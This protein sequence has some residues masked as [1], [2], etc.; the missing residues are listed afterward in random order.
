MNPIWNSMRLLMLGIVY[1]WLSNLGVS[2]SHVLLLKTSL[3]E[4]EPS[5]KNL[6]KAAFRNEL[7]LLV[8][9]GMMLAQFM[10]ILSIY[11]P[12]L[13]AFWLKPHVWSLLSTPY[14]FFY[15]CKMLMASM[16]MSIDDSRYRY[17]D[18][19]IKRHLFIDSFIGQ[20]HN[21]IVLPTPLFVRVLSSSLFRYSQASMFMSGVLVGWLGGS[22][23]LILMTCML[24]YTL[25]R[26]TPSFG[27]K[28]DVFYF[29]FFRYFA[30]VFAL[31][32]INI[33]PILITRDNLPLL[34]ANTMR[35]KD[36][37]PNI[38]FDSTSYHRQLWFPT[39][40]DG[41]EEQ[42]LIIETVKEESKPFIPKE[43]LLNY[44]RVSQYF[45]RESVHAG[46]ARLL[47]NYPASL[48]IAHENLEIVLDYPFL[49]QDNLDRIYDE[50]LEDKIERRDE[51]SL[52]VF[53]RLSRINRLRKT[54]EK[55]VQKKLILNLETLKTN[56]KT[57]E[58]QHANINID[59]ILS[60]NLIGKNSPNPNVSVVPPERRKL[61]NFE[62][63][64]NNQL[65]EWISDKAQDLQEIVLL[66]WE[67]L[68]STS[69]LALPLVLNN[70]LNNYDPVFLH[71]N[72][73]SWDR[74]VQAYKAPLIP[75]YPE[76][77]T[78]WFINGAAWVYNVDL[79]S[80]FANWIKT[81]LQK[82]FGLIENLSQEEKRI[83]SFAA[84]QQ[85]LPLYTMS[86]YNEEGDPIESMVNRQE[87]P[88][89]GEQLLAIS[90]NFNDEI[91]L[92]HNIPR[93]RKGQLLKLRQLQFLPPSVIHCKALQEE[94]GVNNLGLLF[95]SEFNTITKF[96]YQLVFHQLKVDSN[97]NWDAITQALM[98]AYYRNL[99]IRNRQPSITEG[100][101]VLDSHFNNI[102]GPWLI[103]QFYLRKYVRLPLMIFVKHA[104]RMFFQQ[105]SELER[106]L[107]E[108]LQEESRICIYKGDEA[109]AP[110][111]ETAEE[112]EEEDKKS[113]DKLTSAEKA[114]DINSSESAKT[115]TINEGEDGLATSNMDPLE[116]EIKSIREDLDKKSKKHKPWIFP[117]NWLD[118]GIQIKILY[119]FEFKFSHD[120]LDYE[121]TFYAKL[122]EFV[123]NYPHLASIVN[124]Q[125]L[126]G[127][128]DL[129][130]PESCYLDMMGFEVETPAGNQRTFRSTFSLNIKLIARRFVLVSRIRIAKILTP[131]LR[132]PLWQILARYYISVYANIK[133]ILSFVK[134][135]LIIIVETIQKILQV[136]ETVM[137]KMRT[138]QKT[139]V[140]SPNIMVSSR[141][142]Q[143]ASIPST[144]KKANRIRQ[145]KSV[146]FPKFDQFIQS[147]LENTLLTRYPLFE[148]L[149]DALFEG[150]SFKERLLF[151]LHY[152][153]SQIKFLGIQI[154]KSSVFAKQ[155]LKVLLTIEYPTWIKLQ[156]QLLPNSLRLLRPIITQ[157]LI[158]SRDNCLDALDLYIEKIASKILFWLHG[159]NKL[160]KY[161][162]EIKNVD[163]PQKLSLGLTHSF[164]W[165][166]LWE[167]QLAIN[168]HLIKIVEDWED[169][170]VLSPKIHRFLVDEGI[171]EDEVN[172][173]IVHDLLL[174]K[175]HLSKWLRNM[176][177]F[178]PPKLVWSSLK[179]ASKKKRKRII[180][181]IQSHQRNSFSNYQTPQHSLPELYDLLIKSA[182]N[183]SKLTQWYHLLQAYISEYDGIRIQNPRLRGRPVIDRG[184]YVKPYH[185]QFSDFGENT[186]LEY[187][188][189]DEAS[190]QY[191]CFESS[192]DIFNRKPIEEEDAMLDALLFPLKTT[193]SS[194]VPLEN[195]IHDIFKRINRGF[196]KIVND[197]TKFEQYEMKP[198]DIR[199]CNGMSSFLFGQ[200]DISNL[201]EADFETFYDLR[202]R[203]PI[204][205]WRMKLMN[206]SLFTFNFVTP[207]FEFI[208]L[209]KPCDLKNRVEWLLDSADKLMFCRIYESIM[210][211]D[212]QRE[213]RV[214]NL[215]NLDQ[216]LPHSGDKMLGSYSAISK[217]SEEV[218]SRFLWPSHRLE[219][220][221]CMNRFWFG[222]A[223]Q[224][225]S[226]LFRIRMYPLVK[227]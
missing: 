19:H 202:G 72:N 165:E 31:I 26:F 129:Q 183:W 136:I 179:I 113:T 14:I 210:L 181:K 172:S 131:I 29:D 33:S 104:I 155:Y 224:S 65:K 222:V 2:K 52:K 107:E 17:E 128:T 216:P 67:P 12:P 117:E 78:F 147:K 53:K 206:E 79:M 45:F 204:L 27:K 103:C 102:R 213:F 37:W 16:P 28:F 13:Y 198:L 9:S 8:L 66:P 109:Q 215:L 96:K 115:N 40:K 221:A 39:S 24:V 158:N 141:S 191:F 42:D 61:N 225:K 56:Q 193:R 170:Q 138:V 187:L 163:K 10:V 180:T 174:T 75:D 205:N 122:R 20:L 106:D 203:A 150:F 97:R 201:D 173:N 140:P 114:K 192:M 162:I 134:K 98:S 89:I 182:D 152:K 186:N 214:L 133:A 38:L 111:E 85:N 91:A 197:D 195:S 130:K 153:F 227:P 6:V 58:I 218:F 3:Y 84:L 43:M 51:I 74:F 90:P 194:Y 108:L 22:I 132:F 41:F 30:V 5:K 196:F 145:R 32:S 125:E 88:D 86:N 49:S 126:I 54:F 11:L 121:K 190:D 95:L 82:Q 50:W 87:E 212:L 157:F 184:S 23:L 15:A 139:I 68:S 73:F 175:Q 200:P 127:E 46:K 142:T 124:V 208:N 112:E 156:I 185:P 188:E 226:S 159:S 21:P 189:R 143:Q 60:T 199:R 35:L 137:L 166:K 63:N 64:E 177:H 7:I 146:S 94:E 160:T 119:P 62:D 44:K 4:L 110:L 18:L 93:K 77:E 59:P 178:S 118:D 120:T 135:A 168:P 211:P 148:P 169:D 161:E 101:Q 154:R 80:Y 36:T 167:S 144:I 99:S 220:L 219:D 164:I 55:V 71:N 81:S 151:S 217:T 83:R 1:S 171:S 100:L 92:R 47:Y 69:C 176:A 34:E 48:A 223:N 116:E 70:Q 123:K 105:S 57:I 76:K 209:A 149:P 207:L 25:E